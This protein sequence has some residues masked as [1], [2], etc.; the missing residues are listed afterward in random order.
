VTA[1]SVPI[2][3]RR[4]RV[5]QVL[6]PISL[7]HSLIYLALLAVWLIP[8]MKAEEMAFGLI[9]GVTWIVMSLVCVTLASRR[10]L[11]VRTASAVAIVGGIG[12]FVGTYEFMRLRREDGAH[13]RST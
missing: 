8:G 4:Q 10:L 9:H 12:P 6:G 13:V 2:D 7:A 1:T 5:A 3:L 11:P